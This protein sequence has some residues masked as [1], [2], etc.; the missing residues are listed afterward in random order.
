MRGRIVPKESITSVVKGKLST[1]R[2]CCL[3]SC[4]NPSYSALDHTN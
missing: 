3:Q 4:F 1:I 2:S